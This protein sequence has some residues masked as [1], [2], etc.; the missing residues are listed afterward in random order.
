MNV[1]LVYPRYPVTFWSFKYAVKFVG[2]KTAFPPLGLLTVAAMLP[3][4][5]NLRL[6]DLNIRKLSDRDLR[7]ADCVMI[8][9]MLVQKDSVDRV[10]TR[11]EQSGKTT[12]AGGPL[13][14]A[15]PDEYADRVNHLVLGEAEQ[16]LPVFLKDLAEGRALPL[17]RAEGFPDLSKTPLPRLDLIRGKDYASMMIQ[18]SRGC[19]FDCEFC[20]VTTLFG[21]RQRLKKASRFIDELQA[22]YDSGWRE[23]VFVVDDNFIG[24]KRAIKA[25]LPSVIDWME[26][27][28]HPFTLFTEASV[29]IAEDDELIDLMVRAGFNNV[30]IGLETPNEESLRECSK[31]QNLKHD[32][33]TSIR[34]LQHRGLGVMGGYIVGFDSDD[35][36][37]FSRQ[38]KFIQESGVVTAMVGLL[39]ALPNTRLWQRLKEEDRLA[40]AATGNN[41]DGSLN[42]IPAMDREKLLEGYRNL[43]KTIYNPKY[44]YERLTM[45]LDNYKPSGVPRKRPD[46]RQLTAFFKSMVYMG[47]LG[48]GISQWYYWKMVVKAAVRYRSAFTEAITLM[49]YGHHFRKVAK[50]L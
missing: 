2:K 5:W 10:L 6:V 19:P 29:N 35:E 4:D 32:L 20:D 46:F 38:V 33:T 47:V 28:G 40:D 18:F 41:T 23:S 31:M 17:Y 42:F 30:F 27:H 36:S 22:I 45:F 14:T 24:N 21:H 15:L 7:W 12:I 1:L 16:I 37:I 25:M 44:F 49:I 3:G 50:R 39:Q 13:F 48:N 9:A 43:V 11:C 26:R 34:K 8:S